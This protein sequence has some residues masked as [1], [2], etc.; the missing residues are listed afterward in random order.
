MF[1]LYNSEWQLLYFL[2]FLDH[3]PHCLLAHSFDDKKSVN[4]TL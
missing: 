2:F 3:F 4:S 1:L